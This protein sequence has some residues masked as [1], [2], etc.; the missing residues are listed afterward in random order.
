MIIKNK[1]F[2]SGTIAVMVGVVFVVLITTVT[3]INSTV[4]GIT[5]GESSINMKTLQKAELKTETKT[6][7]EKS[8]ISYQTVTVDDPNLE[9]G[10]TETRTKGV[11]GEIIYTYNI[12]YTN[13]KEASRELVGKETT[14][15]PLNE[16]IARGTKVV[17][18]CTDVTS[19]D[20]NPY[21][22]NKC[23]SSTGEV[24]YVSDSQSVVLD[25]AYSPG[26]SGAY[27]YNNK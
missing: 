24:K 6:V 25:P 16:I 11:T 22:D 7:I 1:N 13:G 17:W 21:N 8:T 27:Y 18:H 23:T 12:I 14:K 2:T 4:Y 26:K 20:R 10:K 19:Y 9:Y 15:Q 3:I 5:K